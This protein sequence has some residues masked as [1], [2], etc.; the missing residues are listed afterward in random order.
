M[1]GAQVFRT[2]NHVGELVDLIQSTCRDYV[3]DFGLYL[4]ELHVTWDSEGHF[5]TVAFRFR[6]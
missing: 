4:E 3:S 5:Y 6:K 1:G 2:C